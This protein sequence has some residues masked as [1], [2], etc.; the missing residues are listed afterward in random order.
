[1]KSKFSA[2]VTRR[3]TIAV[4]LGLTLFL[5]FS[6]LIQ[7]AI[8]PVEKILPNDTLFVL[9]TPDYS[10]LR[11]IYSH[12]P[13]SQFW[14]DPA[15]KPFRDKFVGKFKEQLV[16]PLERELRVHFD[17]YTGLPGGQLTLAV[18]RNG[19]DAKEPGVVLL[20][21]TRNKSD[22]L[23]KDLS[24]LRKKWVDAGK[25]MHTEKVGNIEF[26]VLPVS[27]NDLP[28]TLKQVFKGDSDDES[29]ASSTDNGETNNAPPAA[30]NQI[31]IGQYESLL[32]LGDSLKTVEGIVTRLTG[33]MAPALAEVATFESDQ[34]TTFRDAPLYAWV[35]VRAILDMVVKQTSDD[36]GDTT[37]ITRPQPPSPQKIIAATGLGGVKSIA[38][39]YRDAGDG[40]AAQ[41]FVNSPDS[42]RQGFIKIISGEAKET[43]PPSFVPMNVM[44]FQRW[45][46]DGQK[47]WATLQKM[48]GDI[49]PTWLNAINFMIDTANSAAKEKNPD[50]DLRKNLIGNLGD[51]I[52]SYQKTPRE[53]TAAGL[54]AAPSLLLIGSPKPE[55]LAASL[56]S[57]FRLTS[58]TTP[59]EREFL[60]HK[61]YSIT[62][63]SRPMG[64]PEPGEP[65]TR[66]LSYAAGRGYVALTTDPASLE[67]YLRSSENP[68]KALRETPGLAEA[69]QKVTGAGTS[70]FGYEN[71]NEMM[72]VMFQICKNSG[73]TNAPDV[74]PLSSIMNA[75]KFKEWLDFSLLPDF[76]Q[77]SKY[78]YF[79]VFGSSSS[80]NGITFKVFAPVPPQL[81]K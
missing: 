6:S 9:T 39:S 47:T 12:S 26:M 21:D 7:A 5:A 70:L 3:N 23:K 29:D 80:V 41:L 30:K 8:P 14:N 22:L 66:A 4:S 17:D 69:A 61:I 42:A 2:L 27:T 1:M 68:P 55:D 78:F 11:E 72:R 31:V 46:I 73:G 19:S 32:I 40:S 48:V 51:D 56:G 24:D 38:L 65:L 67:E 44:K 35:N 59:K 60:G 79:D 33:G 50:F 62:I 43:S 28:K 81:K 53:M 63:P 37:D 45:R 75:P 18:T 74:S 52:I 76:E 25:V 77:I 58:Q 71:Q 20:M 36:Q 15:M 34:M 57:L 64:L 13:Q 10:K 49:S 54:N 16:T